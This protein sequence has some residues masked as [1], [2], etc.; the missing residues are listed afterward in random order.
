[1][2]SI[3]GANMNFI[4]ISEYGENGENPELIIYKKR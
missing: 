2:E 4:I 1:M 3:C